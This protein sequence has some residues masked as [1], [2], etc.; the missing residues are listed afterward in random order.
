MKYAKLFK[1]RRNCLLFRIIADDDRLCEDYSINNYDRVKRVHI[2]D[3]VDM[4]EYTNSD[5][6]DVLQSRDIDYNPLYQSLAVY[7]EEHDISYD[8]H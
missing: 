5:G 8:L 6:M 2:E 1:L 4:S 3:I 7:R